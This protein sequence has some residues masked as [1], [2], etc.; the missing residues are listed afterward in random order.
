MSK[1]LFRK[2]I[3]KPLTCSLEGNIGC[4]KSEAIKHFSGYHDVQTLSEPDDK[5]QNLKGYNLLHAMYENPQKFTFPLQVYVVN[6]R[7]EQLA[8]PC[9]Q[10]V[11]VVERS[12]DSSQFCFMKLAEEKGHLSKV[13]VDILKES[14]SSFQ[15]RDYHRIDAHIYLDASVDTCYQR[16][17]E[18]DRPAERSISKSL[19]KEL[20]T[21][22]DRWLRFG[23]ARC[24]VIKVDA[25]QEA[26]VVHAALEEALHKV[27]T[28]PYLY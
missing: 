8:H 19:L 22:H 11:R 7:I 21:A 27:A 6:T 12:L 5:W 17:M 24:P 9:Y 28:C 4:G 23:V 13:E 26:H 15:D 14:I 10:P 3:P 2:I 25:N 18:R 20:D 16:I 1:L